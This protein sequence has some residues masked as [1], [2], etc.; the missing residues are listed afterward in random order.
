VNCDWEYHL[1]GYFVWCLPYNSPY[2]QVFWAHTKWTVHLI[3][4]IYP[5]SSFFNHRDINSI[6]GL[7]RVGFPSQARLVEGTVC[8]WNNAFSYNETKTMDKVHWAETYCNTPSSATFR[9]SSNELCLKVQHDMQT[10]A[11]SED[12]VALFSKMNMC[13]DQRWL[14]L[15]GLIICGLNP[16]FICLTIKK[17]NVNF[18][19]RYIT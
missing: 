14:E 18:L 12:S 4:C 10:T 5:P 16:S 11:T 17:L 3:Y 7:L 15:Y 6:T 1:Y 8:F 9:N 2:K 19:K 13:P